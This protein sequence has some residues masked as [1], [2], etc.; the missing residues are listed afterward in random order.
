MVSSI[1]IAGASSVGI[2]PISSLMKPEK[3]MS[4][5]Y[6]DE[7]DKSELLLHDKPDHCSGYPY[8]L[9]EFDDEYATSDEYLHDPEIENMFRL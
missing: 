9:P 1:T 6:A 3:R 8:S 2:S 7:I 5:I 4:F